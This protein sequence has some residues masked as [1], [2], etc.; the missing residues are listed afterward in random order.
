LRNLRELT[1][2]ICV[3]ET[4][5]ARQTERIDCM[6]GSSIEKLQGNGIAVIQSDQNHIEGDRQVVL[7]PTLAALYDLLHAVG[8]KQVY[9]AVPPQNL[10]RYELSSS[11]QQ[12][13]DFD[14]VVLFAQV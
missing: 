8:F 6:W 2:E 12:F 3:I 11:T 9:L 10:T 5:V 4:Q 14:R 1:R 13:A 7:V